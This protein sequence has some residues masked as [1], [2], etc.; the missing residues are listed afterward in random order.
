MARLAKR[1]AHL[2]LPRRTLGL[3]ARLPARSEPQPPAALRTGARAG[4][5]VA[6]RRRASACTFPPYAGVGHAL[7]RHDARTAVELFGAREGHLDAARMGEAG[8]A[9]YVRMDGDVHG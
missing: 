1:A 3:V 6:A 2:G 4:G 5:G 7:R 8:E 9:R